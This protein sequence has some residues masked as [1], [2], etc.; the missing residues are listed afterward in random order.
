MAIRARETMLPAEWWSTYGGSC[1][2]LAHLAIRALSQ[3]CSSCGLSL[4]H[5]PF[6][7]LHDVRNCP[8][9]LR[10]R[11]L[12]FVQYN[13]R[14]KQLGSED[15]KQDSMNPL[16]IDAISVVE[17]WIRVKDVCLQDYSSSDWM[18]HNLSV[19]NKMILGPQ[20]DGF[21]QLRAGFDDYEIFKKVKDE[22]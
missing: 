7:Q 22:D 3:S 4:N 15:K 2:H 5:I 10:L 21:D 8:E 13:L 14:L 6:E 17:D 20:V 16:S 19:V 11:D 18:A 1:P 12:I 9:H